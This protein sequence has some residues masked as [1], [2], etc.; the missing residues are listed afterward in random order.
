MYA[1]KKEN[2]KSLLQT[3]HVKHFY[4]VGKGQ[5]F[6][7]QYEPDPLRLL[8]ILLWTNPLVPEDQIASFS[9]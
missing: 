5:Y 8:R 9:K 3:H 7:N 6:V 1:S 4:L 2:K